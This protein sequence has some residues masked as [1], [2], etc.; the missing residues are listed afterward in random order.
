MEHLITEITKLVVDYLPK[1]SIKLAFFAVYLFITPK[2]VKLI[3][4]AFRKLMTK[5]AMDDLLISFLDSLLMALGYVVLLLG[6]VAILG[7]ETTSFVAFLGT[8]GLGVGL[9]LQGSLSN[10]AG[11]VLILVFRQF[12]K[13]DY[14]ATTTTGIEGV[15]ESIRILY[16]TLVTPNNQ[17]IIVPNSQLANS[18]VINYTHTQTRRLD[19]TY[20][21]SYDND[22]DLVI[23]TL[24][25]VAKE[26]P[27]ILQDQ[28]MIIR[29]KQHN[30]SSLDYTFRVWTKVTDFWDV[31][32]DCNENVKKAFDAAGIEIPYNKLDVYNRT[33]E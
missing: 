29:L 19:L 7:V 20:S 1:L 9:A 5:R 17:T 30:S 27:K 10:L 18:S 32:F 33:N 16:T 8:M 12:T 21:A 4:K 3:R 14:I 31:V 28:P 6:S 23:A 15:V 22:V 13:G 2:L 24:T 26:H 25:K 11:G